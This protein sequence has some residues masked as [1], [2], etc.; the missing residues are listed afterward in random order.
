M[1]AVEGRKRN[2]VEHEE[3][4]IDDG[5]EQQEIDY[6]QTE[7]GPAEIGEGVEKPGYPEYQDA[8]E[9]VGNRAGE[10]DE[11]LVPMLVFQIIRVELHG[12]GPAET[13]YD[14]QE[15]A[16]R[17]DVLERVQREPTLLFCRGVPQLIP[18]AI[19]L[20]MSESLVKLW[21]Q[22][23]RILWYCP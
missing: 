3:A 5:P 19:I 9:K 4:E 15:E 22:A 2:Q 23:A 20:Y 8:H 18:H 11:Y 13:R 17:I 21:N 14:D 16:E 10:G 1:G 7:I 6:L 12:L